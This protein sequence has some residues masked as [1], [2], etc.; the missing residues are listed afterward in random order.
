MREDEG[1][2]ERNTLAGRGKVRQREKG[3][4]ADQS[5]LIGPKRKQNLK[6]KKPGMGYEKNDKERNDQNHS[7]VFTKRY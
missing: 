5:N 7:I 6:T 4:S 2:E 1:D 3:K